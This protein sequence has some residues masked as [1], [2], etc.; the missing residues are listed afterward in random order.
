MKV[1]SRTSI[2]VI[3]SQG[4]LRSEQA[5]N[6]AGAFG[7]NIGNSL[8]TLSGQTLALGAYIKDQETQKNR[9]AALKQYAE[10]EVSEKLALNDATRNSTPGDST[11]YQSQFDSFK[12]REKEFL[13]AL[14]PDLQEEFSVRT[15]GLG[16]ELG[17]AAANHQF[18]SNDLFFKQGIQDVVDAS[19]IEIGQD[20]SKE[21][22]EKQRLKVDEVIAASGLTEAE[23]IAAQRKAHAGLEGV[24]YRQAQLERLRAEN[25]GS[26]SDV[27]QAADILAAIGDLDAD[28]AADTALQAAQEAVTIFGGVDKWAA[29][30]PRVRAALVTA[31]ATTGIP[32]AAVAAVANGDLE[33]LATALRDGGAEIPGDLI[34][35]PESSIDNDP[36]YAN[37]PYE[38]RLILLGDAQRQ[39]TA[40]V[41]AETKANDA[42]NAELINALEVAIHD[43]E[44]G[45][46]DYD[47]LRDMGVITDYKDMARIEKQIAD[48]D[49]ELRLAT[50]GMQMATGGVTFAPGN[51]EHGKA[52][53]AVIGEAGLAAIENREADYAA[54]VLIPLVRNAGAVPSD[55]VDLL[56]GMIRKDNE[57]AYWA[58]DLMSQIKRTDEKAFDSFPEADQKSVD[59]WEARRDYLSPEELVKAINGPMDTSERDGR[60]ELRKRGEAL[61]TKEGSAMRNFDPVSLFDRGL[62]GGGKP[63]LTGVAWAAPLLN[64]DFQTL[65]LDAYE[66]SGNEQYATEA[67]KKQLERVWGVTN[68]GAD[69]KLMRY[70]PEKAY[71]TVRD[72]HDWLEIQLRREEVLLPNEQF[73]LISD[74]QTENERATGAP[75]YLFVKIVDGVHTIPQDANGLPI[76]VNF[77]WG[78]E[79]ELDESNWRAEQRKMLEV[80]ESQRLLGLAVQHE[81]DTGTA[82]PPGLFEEDQ[83]G[84]I[85]DHMMNDD[86]EALTEAE[87]RVREMLFGTPEG[88]DQFRN[89]LRTEYG[90]N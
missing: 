63:S 57:T 64:R 29:L 61:F 21:N 86:P 25:D 66:L 65:F 87:R 8:A 75:S 13:S 36:A 82:I 5:Q 15:T 26:A 12:Q 80:R 72:S 56:Q 38:D 27:D 83:P 45:M 20:G 3:A 73:E 19:R 16:G 9:F 34:L 33:A 18:A 1:P 11:F 43:G 67:A 60:A 42:R 22:L 37:V 78:A 69:N 39:L 71:P 58:L 89:G 30:P 55:V 14:P 81:M 24:A 2:G 53:N 7:E 68:T 28:E 59:F 17:L 40:E 31:Q 88:W 51:E 35:N 84:G 50:L 49:E 77:N 85:L 6:V 48:R 23:K 46:A 52:L 41:T 32:Q 70:P 4:T 54:N 62:F 44:A 76:R 74:D 90:N 47:A 10:F 79:E